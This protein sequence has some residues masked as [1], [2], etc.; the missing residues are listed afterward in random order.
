MGVVGFFPKVPF[1]GFFDG[2]WNWG[3]GGKVGTHGVEA[4]LISGV[5]D[6]VLA[7]VGSGKSEA[8]IGPLPSQ[9]TLA[10]L[11]AISG[12]VTATQQHQRYI[13]DLKFNADS[14]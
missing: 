4:V 13:L 7:T 3:W 5:R 12:L 11:D 10:G 9:T 2:L 14:T 1:N 8:T 6:G